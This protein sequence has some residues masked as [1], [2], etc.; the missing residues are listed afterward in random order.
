MPSSTQ[1]FKHATRIDGIPFSFAD[2]S[3]LLVQARKRTVD[4]GRSRAQRLVDGF[5]VELGNI[6]LIS[7]LAIKPRFPGRRRLT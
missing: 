6:T 2:P 4:D 3:S 7:E 5:G 1:Q